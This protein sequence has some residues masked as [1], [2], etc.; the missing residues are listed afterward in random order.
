MNWKKIKI[1]S[2]MTILRELEKNDISI[3]GEY[4]VVYSDGEEEIKIS[5]MRLK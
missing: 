5:Y 4:A 2:I 1:D 3:F